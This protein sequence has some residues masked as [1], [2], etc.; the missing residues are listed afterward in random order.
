VETIFQYRTHYL[1]HA[2]VVMPDH[3]HLIFTPQDVP[4]ERA[5]QYIKVGF[6]YRY[7][8]DRKLKLQVWQRGYTDHRIRDMKDYE[9]RKRYVEQNRV[10]RGLVESAEKFEYSSANGVVSMDDYLR[11]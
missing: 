8:A 9:A 11:G 4:L 3:F 1:L 2:Y 6:S 5:M 10:V 7:N